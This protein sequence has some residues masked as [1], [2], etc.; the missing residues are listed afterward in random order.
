MTGPIGMRVVAQVVVIFGSMQC[1]HYGSD[2]RC[3][4]GLQHISGQDL[5]GIRHAVG[6][7]EA[8]RLTCSAMH[9]LTVKCSMQYV[10]QERK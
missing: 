8:V 5:S 9:V 3:K 7:P 10:H 6:S 2:I 4:S 1:L